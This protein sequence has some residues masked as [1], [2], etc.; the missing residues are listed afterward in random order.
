MR[1][2]LLTQAPGRLSA[3]RAHPPCLPRPAEHGWGGGWGPPLP[4]HGEARHTSEGLRLPF[5]KPFSYKKESLK[6]FTPQREGSQRQSKT[7]KQRKNTDRPRRRS[8][9]GV[10]GLHSCEALVCTSVSELVAPVRADPSLSL[11]GRAGMY[12]AR[13]GPFSMRGG[14]E[15]GN[16]LF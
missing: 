11:L 4:R 5:R 1:T 3:H 10:L 6:V 14:L 12:Q 16:L 8:A 13:R 7:S 15:K 9:Q 2:H